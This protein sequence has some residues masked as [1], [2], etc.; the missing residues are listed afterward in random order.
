MIVK[1]SIW[2]IV[3]DHVDTLRNVRS[4]RY[5]PLDF[6]SLFLLPVLFSGVIT[7]YDY[8]LSKEIINAL[9]S[10]L[11]VFAALLFNL[12]LL[13]YSIVQKNDAAGLEQIRAK[14][15]RAIYAN[16]SF[17]ILLTVLTIALLLITFIGIDV[18]G[19]KQILTFIVYSLTVAFLLTLLM[20][21]RRVHSLL[22]GEM[23]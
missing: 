19:F 15:L 11:S 4:G 6:I 22:F 18:P 10:S 3:V 5:R 14:F 9:L 2:R 21:L 12:L 7:Y 13:V 1:F 20:I 8:T 23:T 16:I 17:S